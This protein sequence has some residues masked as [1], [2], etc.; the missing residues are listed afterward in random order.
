M[1]QKKAI[2]SGIAFFV[3][4]SLQTFTTANSITQA[5]STLAKLLAGHKPASISHKPLSHRHI[6]STAKFILPA[7]AGGILG[8]IYARWFRWWR[9]S[10]KQKKADSA[11]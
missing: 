2:P 5:I 11:L 1:I 4:W 8:P 9:R 3:S 10:R 7:V 6:H